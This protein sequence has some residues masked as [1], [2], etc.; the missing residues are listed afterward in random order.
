MKKRL[1]CGLCGHEMK[2]SKRK[3][4]KWENGDIVIY[5]NECWKREK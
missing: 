4:K 3:Y 1:D 5:C 2:V